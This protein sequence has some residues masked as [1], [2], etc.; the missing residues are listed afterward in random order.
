MSL[1]EKLQRSRSKER[2]DFSKYQPTNNQNPLIKVVTGE[3]IL[4]EPNWTIPGEFEG[5]M[6]ADYISEHP[7]YDGIYVRSELLKRLEVAASALAMPYQLVVRAGHRPIDV[8]KRLLKECADDYK[9][10]NPGASDEEALEPDK[11]P[12]AR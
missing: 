5:S 1:E 2:I 11:N 8:Q 10:G 9:S 4:V 3:K 7:E 12:L 6:Y